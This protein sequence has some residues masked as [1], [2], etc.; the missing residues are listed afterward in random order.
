MIE[1][2]VKRG[3]QF[4]S[5]RFLRPN[6][7]KALRS[8]H[9]A[10]HAK[11]IMLLAVFLFTDCNS[12]K[13]SSLD[14]WEPFL[15]INEIQLTSDEKGH[16]LNPVQV[17]SPDDSWIVYDTRNDGTHIGQNCCI[18]MVNTST[19]EIKLL[20]QAPDQ[21]IYG[22]GTGAATFSPVAGKVLFI[23]GL[24]N[25]DSGRPY[26]FSRRT[27]MAVS[28]DDP[29]VPV[30]M[31]ARDI[32]DP[33]TAGALRGG[34]HAHSWSGDGEWIS[35][36]YN[37]DLLARLEREGKSNVMDLRMV[38]VMGPY[39][40]VHVK[41][42]ETGENIGGKKFS[43][44]VTSVTETPEP[45]TDEINRAY[46][47][48]WVGRYGYKK[49]GQSTQQRAVAFLG[50]TRDKNGN[51]LTEVFIADI[52]D[53]ITSEIPGQPLAGTPTTRP[54]PPGGTVQRRLTFTAGNKYPGVQ[55]PRHWMSSPPDGSQIFFM[56]MDMQGIT[57]VYAVSPNGGEIS[58]VT[59]NAFP[60][61]TAFSVCPGAQF[62]AYGY[63]EKIFITHIETGE[64]RQI[65]SE[66]GEGMTGLESINWSNNGKMIASNRKVSVAD[67]SYYQIFLLK[68]Q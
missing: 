9:P 14:I 60:V 35:F 44:I 53:D 17:F 59:R 25:S 46:E 42:D 51:I 52:P 55:G 48:G 30:S 57:Q 12:G 49:P 39:G 45:G 56:M 65:S 5:G 7:L 61:E 27:G 23:H 16:F 32:S 10:K 63:A 29:G 41:E 47:D 18:E 62:I 8:V 50:D 43:V 40:P 1:Y 11:W 38:G 4:R 3:H 15:N 13:K 19:K 64:T 6:H 20:Y 67:T 24:M 37:D 31:D 22:P 2:L 21:T 26:G 28:L 68:L 36:T 34:T 33:F 66:P 58:Q 54:A